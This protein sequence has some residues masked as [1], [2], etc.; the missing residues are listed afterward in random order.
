M[1][2]KAANGRAMC[3]QMVIKHKVFH[4]KVWLV[5]R[6]DALTR[7]APQRAEAQV[8]TEPL[9]IS[10]VIVSGFVAFMHIVPVPVG[11]RISYHVLLGSH[12]QL[13]Q[14]FEWE[15]HGDLDV[16]VQNRF[17][18]GAEIAAVAAITTTAKHRFARGDGRDQVGVA[19]RADI[20][21]VVW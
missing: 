18:R 19:G 20:N 13:L 16:N 7:S 4:Q 11:N 3:S 2:C 17:A 5:E 10:I 8:I 21:H 6:H 14:F 15:Y 9:C 1:N 12:F